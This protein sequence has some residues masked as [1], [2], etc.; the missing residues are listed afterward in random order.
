MQLNL[1]VKQ[2]SLLPAFRA[3]LAPVVPIHR[4]LLLHAGVVSSC[5]S[6]GCLAL[7][8]DCLGYK[9]GGLLTEKGSKKKDKCA[10]G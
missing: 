5:V 6:K 1:D 2:I 9:E 4:L 3:V 10:F 7:V 8:T